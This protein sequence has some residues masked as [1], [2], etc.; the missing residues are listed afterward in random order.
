MLSQNSDTIWWLVKK[1]SPH[2]AAVHSVMWGRRSKRIDPTELEREDE[3]SRF[4]NRTVMSKLRD[5]L[6]RNRSSGLLVE[7]E[8]G[9]SHGGKSATLPARV[10][11]E[12]EG[13]ARY[14]AAGRGV[15][16][17]RGG[18]RDGGRTRTLYWM[19][20]Y[21]GAFEEGMRGSPGVTRKDSDESVDS[22]FEQAAKT[23]GSETESNSSPAQQSKTLPPSPSLCH[24]GSEASH[25]ALEQPSPPL[26]HEASNSYQE[27]PPY[28][29]VP[30]NSMYDKAAFDKAFGPMKDIGRWYST[31]SSRQQLQLARG[32]P[33]AVPRREKRL[34]DTP[35][36][37]EEGGGGGVWTGCAHQ[38]LL[39]QCP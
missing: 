39:H 29:L 28:Q 18:G 30:S 35:D 13:E 9:L 36:E 11:G 31:Y 23:E 20:G 2:P 33:V 22:G 32:Q 17:G 24:E 10:R 7:T 4:R 16:G 19:E 26:C 21:L 37:E 27:E 25:E 12:E 8:R 6:S 38:D 5:R 34:P 1:L 15:G 14:G 3:D